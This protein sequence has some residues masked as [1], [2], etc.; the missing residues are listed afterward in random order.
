[1][2]RRPWLPWAFAG[3][4]LLLTSQIGMPRT[5]IISYDARDWFFGHVLYGLIA[6]TF[7]LPAMLGDPGSRGLPARVLGWPPIA[8][9]GLI[10]YGVFLWH[11]PLCARFRGVQDWTSHGSF[12]IYTLV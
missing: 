3:G 9:L 10:S 12:I 7:A 11:Q 8:W 4:L 6:I 2:A 5:D 1:V